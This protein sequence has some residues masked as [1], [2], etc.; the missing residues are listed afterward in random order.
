M[1]GAMADK[2]KKCGALVFARF[3]DLTGSL[4][5]KCAGE[6]SDQGQA[7]P[8]KVKR[9]VTD[10][11][12]AKR[13]PIGFDM[14][15]REIASSEHE[16]NG[17]VHLMQTAQQAKRETT[18]SEHVGKTEK[19]ETRSESLS[20]HI[21]FRVTPTMDEQ[22][23]NLAQVKSTSVPDLIRKAIRALLIDESL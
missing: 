2:C 13:N 5:P 7:V 16:R 23:R 12:A 1:G 17:D 15:K 10:L 22:L 20:E 11:K 9:I 4:C 19:P 21:G 18:P 8:E 6:T 14:A 3:A